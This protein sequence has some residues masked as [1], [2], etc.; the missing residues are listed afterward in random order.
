MIRARADAGR[1]ENG[2]MMVRIPTR[3]RMPGFDIKLVY[4]GSTMTT[5]SPRTASLCAVKCSSSSFGAP[6]I[7]SS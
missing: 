1:P 2:A 4:Q 3:I 7:T 5:N 6:E